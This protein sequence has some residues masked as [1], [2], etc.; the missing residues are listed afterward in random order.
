MEGQSRGGFIVLEGPDG[1]GTSTHAKELAK[2]LKKRTRN[3]VLTSEPTNG[4]VGKLIT[5]MLRKREGVNQQMLQLLFCAD[6]AEHLSKV[7]VPVLKRGGVVVC[8]RYVPS[9][10]AYGIA[11]GLSDSWL[12]LITTEARRPDLLFFALPPPD[13]CW[14]RLEKRRGRKDTFEQKAF[15]IGVYRQYRKMADEDRSIV[16]VDTSGDPVIVADRI[17]LLAEERLF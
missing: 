17:Q 5:T 11:A 8:D 15:Q 2:R 3:V 10:I 6:R 13:V 12:K 9:T 16:A 4:P 1:A 7:I 14:E